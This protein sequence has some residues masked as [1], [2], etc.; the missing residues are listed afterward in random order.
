MISKNEME[1]LTLSVHA[2]LAGHRYQ[3]HYDCGWC[4]RDH[5]DD[6]LSR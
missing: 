5:S 4:L 1:T 2:D 6:M 3:Q